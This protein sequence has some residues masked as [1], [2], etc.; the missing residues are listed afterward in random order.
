[1]KKSIFVILVLVV[2][3]FSILGTK[4]QQSFAQQEKNE[5]ILSNNELILVFSVSILVVVGI[6]LY[7]ARHRFSQK[8]DAYEKGEFASKNNRDKEKYSSEWLRHP[9]SSTDLG[10]VRQQARGQEPDRRLQ[11]VPSC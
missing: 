2:T 8:K 4:I 3:F 7:M 9:R 5:I 10:A 6:F 11:C 1:M